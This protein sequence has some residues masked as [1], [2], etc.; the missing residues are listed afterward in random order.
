MQETCVFLNGVG[1]VAIRLPVTGTR[2]QN[3][4]GIPCD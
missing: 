2:L 3:R 1:T 4:E